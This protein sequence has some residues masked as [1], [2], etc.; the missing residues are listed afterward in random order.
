MFVHNAPE[1][2]KTVI[3]RFIKYFEQRV[4]FFNNCV[5]RQSFER[6]IKDVLAGKSKKD[7]FFAKYGLSCAVFHILFFC[8]SRG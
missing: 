3:F 7:L 2:V 4:T 5:S 6:N 1:I 8:I